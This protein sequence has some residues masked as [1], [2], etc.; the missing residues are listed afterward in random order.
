[1]A[2]N[3]Q[4][5][6]VFQAIVMAFA[7]FVPM[8]TAL[9]SEKNA[10]D[11][12]GW[13]DFKWDNAH[14]ISNIQCGAEDKTCEHDPVFGNYPVYSALYLYSNNAATKVEKVIGMYKMTEGCHKRAW[15]NTKHSWD[16][17]PRSNMA[18][19]RVRTCVNVEGPGDDKCYWGNL[20]D[21]PYTSG[22]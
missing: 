22:S 20:V 3:K 16:S 14:K 11:V 8:A 5:P 1:M 15:D 10:N 9:R 7:L 17:L 12:Y 4:S 21:N 13:C 18:K 19:A 2:N 6:S